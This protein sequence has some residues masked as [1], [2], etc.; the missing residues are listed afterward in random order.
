MPRLIA[1]VQFNSVARRQVQTE[2]VYQLFV[3]IGRRWNRLYDLKAAS[4]GDAF[5]EAMLRLKPEHFDKQIR[6]EEKTPKGPLRG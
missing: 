2:R 5:R 6:L 3:K 4:H 1:K